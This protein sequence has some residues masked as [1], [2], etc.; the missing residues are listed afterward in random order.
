MSEERGA[1]LFR[2]LHAIIDAVTNLNLR[3]LE[4]EAK[5][6]SSS[7]AEEG[8]SA[9]AS[10]RGKAKDPNPDWTEVPYN[11][12][13]ITPLSTRPRFSQ[14][15][16]SSSES[17]IVPP[18]RV[19]L[20]ATS[21]ANYPALNPATVAA[22]AAMSDQAEGQNQGGQRDGQGG[23]QGD[24][25]GGIGDGQGGGGQPP[26]AYHNAAQFLAAW[27]AAPSDQA[28]DNLEQEAIS[29]S[30]AQ[31]V[32]FAA[33]LKINLRM[34]ALVVQLNT[35]VNQ[36]QG[37]VAA[38]NTIARQA[39]AAAQGAANVDRFRPAA[40]PKYG[41]KKKGEHV[42]HWIPVIEDYLR[43]APDA[44]Y[45]RLASSYLE[46]GPRALWTN[47]YE[48]YKRANG[49]A[50]PPNPRQFFRQTLE[51]NYGLQDLDQKYWDTWNSLRMGPSQSVTEYNVD[52]QQALTDLA[53]HVTD[54]QV[55]IE[56]Y[57]AGLQHDLKQLCRASPTGARW[58]RLQD[59]MQYATLQWPM[60]QERI[61]KSKKSSQEPTK[62]GGKRKASGSAGA[63]GSGRSSKPKLGASGKMSDEQY[64]KDMAEKLCHICHQPDHIARN[65]PQNKKA[66]KGKGGKVAAASGSRP[67]DEMS[68]GDF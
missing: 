51:A 45:I 28:K 2:A 37:Q 40:P 57:R 66:K 15:V 44:D 68:D 32:Q 55:K 39:Q 65:C 4:A 21:L 13:P 61:A 24:G 7:S 16:G 34:Q 31:D 22:W 11:P 49:G 19:A 60:V 38:T 18:S 25:G 58:A 35:R 53:G 8:T 36:A 63:K 17:P 59:L 46:G 14:V 5:A 43:T 20:E 54:E 62:V 3:D 41:D 52:F 6:S 29:R 67:E 47:V 27:N 10:A 23:P 9:K 56:K 50:E 33:M 26:L 48:A 64:Q 12:V 42:G 1:E 30:P